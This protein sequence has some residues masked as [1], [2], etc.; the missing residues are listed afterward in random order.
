MFQCIIISNT[1]VYL[2]TILKC[3][4][5]TFNGCQVSLC[6]T[7]VLSYIKNKI[8]LI[9]KNVI[10]INNLKYLIKM[11]LRYKVLCLQFYGVFAGPPS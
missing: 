1:S 2:C 7:F 4:Q 6:R 10:K 3:T 5:C 8:N 9:S 11:V